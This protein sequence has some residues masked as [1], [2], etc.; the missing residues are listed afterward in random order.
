MTRNFFWKQFLW[1][2]LGNKRMLLQLLWS[3]FRNYKPLKL[4]WKKVRDI[5]FSFIKR[6]LDC[7]FWI[8]NPQFTDVDRDW[9]KLVRFMTEIPTFYVDSAPSVIENVL[10][11]FLHE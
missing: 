2:I 11:D 3:L 5:F 10:E 1:K 4:F 6:V 9:E 8:Q 7:W